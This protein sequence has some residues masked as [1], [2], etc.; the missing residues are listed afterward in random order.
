MLEIVLQMVTPSLAHW[1]FASHDGMHS[2]TLTLKSHTSIGHTTEKSGFLQS[3]LDSGAGW[4]K[5][6]CLPLLLL[7]INPSACGIM[8]NCCLKE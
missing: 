1:Q 5:Q 3:F 2:I 7:F 6:Q 8:F 4:A